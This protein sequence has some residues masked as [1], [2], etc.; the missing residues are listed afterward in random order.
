MGRVC[1]TRQ[2][3]K[4]GAGSRLI[5]E[6]E[7]WIREFGVSKI[8]INSQDRAQG[9][10]EKLG[11]KLVPKVN[12]RAYEEIVVDSEDQIPKDYTPKKNDLGFSCVLVEK[13]RFLSFLQAGGETMANEGIGKTEPVNRDGEIWQDI[14]QKI[15]DL[16]YGNVNITVQDG[17]I[18]QVET[19][20]KTRY[21]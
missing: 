1:V 19:S 2:Y 5:D 10:Y 3:Q 4:N 20:Q 17:K 16:N 21:K 14:K 6:A 18:I 12:P 11:Y 7:E 15:S 8:V 9:F 13:I